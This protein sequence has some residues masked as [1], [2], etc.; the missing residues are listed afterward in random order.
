MNKIRTAFIKA[1][2]KIL[3]SGF[4]NHSP[5][6]Y[7]YINNVDAFSYQHLVSEESQRPGI[8]VKQ[9]I[10]E[11]D[12][13]RCCPIGKN[14]LTVIEQDGTIHEATVWDRHE[15]SIALSSKQHTFDPV[16]SDSDECECGLV[17]SAEVHAVRRLP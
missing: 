6:Q 8:A 9:I 10:E 12:L 15:L 17:K 11:S 4:L 16:S 14:G 7:G 1:L 13:F 3:N 5:C 2:L